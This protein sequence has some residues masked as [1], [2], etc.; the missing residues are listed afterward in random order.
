MSISFDHPFT[1]VTP[2]TIPA[3]RRTIY[4]V[5]SVFHL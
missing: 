5:E 3:A 4:H 1:I 2:P